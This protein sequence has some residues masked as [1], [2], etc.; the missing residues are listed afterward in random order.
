MSSP[1]M[2]WNV[3][4]TQQEQAIRRAATWRRAH[5]TAPATEADLGRAPRRPVFKRLASM[6]VAGPGTGGA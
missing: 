6:L 3:A 1:L 2:L 5:P 4:R